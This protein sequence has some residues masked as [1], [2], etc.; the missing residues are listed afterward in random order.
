VEIQ[1]FLIITS[2][3]V[4]LL[5]TG[6]GFAD[7]DGHLQIH[8]N[9]SA[10]GISASDVT[11]VLMSHLHKDHSGGMTMLSNHQQVVSFENA[12]YYINSMEFEAAFK[13]ENP[14]Y[15]TEHF[16]ILLNNDRVRLTDGNGVIDD[17]IKY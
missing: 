11:K 14:S 2:E 6:L 4:L 7:P 9:L 1:P 5:D 10:H 15:K 13:K 12:T 3:D 16:K 8:K 17:Y